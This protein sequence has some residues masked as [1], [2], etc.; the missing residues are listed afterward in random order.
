MIAAPKHTPEEEGQAQREAERSPPLPPI[1]RSNG[2]FERPE[3]RRAPQPAPAR[4]ACRLTHRCDLISFPP[5]AAVCRFSGWPVIFWQCFDLQC[6]GCLQVPT[7][8]PT[9]GGLRWK[10]SVPQVAAAGCACGLLPRIFARV[11][12]ERDYR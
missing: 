9:G 3:S 7:G 5:A 12:L 8:R 4:L 11:N 1:A 10:I 6:F 2:L